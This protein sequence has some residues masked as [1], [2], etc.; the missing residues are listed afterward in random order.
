MQFTITAILA[1][2]M[3]AA[4]APNWPTTTTT[5]AQPTG[6]SSSGTCSNSQK[7]VCCSGDNLLDLSCLVQVIGETCTGGSYCCSTSAG[8]GSLVNIQALDC[9]NLL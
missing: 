4:A 6:T 5:A 3:T 1:L 2:A 9:V 7:Q 8:T